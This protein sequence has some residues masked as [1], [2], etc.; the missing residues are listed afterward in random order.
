MTEERAMKNVI[1]AQ[2]KF[3]VY[4][5]RWMD[6]AKELKRAE[7]KEKDSLL[8]VSK[9]HKELLDAHSVLKKFDR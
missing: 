5:R 2:R 3:D 4:R 9:A 6:N 7:K 1:A 8:A